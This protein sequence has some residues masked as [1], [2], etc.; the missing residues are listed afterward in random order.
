MRATLT[1]NLPDE[2]DAFEMA[3][4]SM[5]LVHAVREWSYAMRQKVKHGDIGDTE[6]DTIDRCRIELQL[7]L[8]AHGV[9]DL[10]NAK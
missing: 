10:I 1:Y 6:A 5:K 9:E 2:Q 7:I 4:R 8:E 3:T